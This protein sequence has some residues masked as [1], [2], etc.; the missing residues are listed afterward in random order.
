MLATRIQNDKEKIYY[1]GQLI[2]S[3]DISSASSD[4]WN[5]SYLATGGFDYDGPSWYTAEMDVAQF[6]AYNVEHSAD[7]IQ[8][9]YNAMK[10]RFL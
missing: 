1:N 3:T 8:Q 4:S 6:L 2:N 7:Q 5:S 10:G 9:S